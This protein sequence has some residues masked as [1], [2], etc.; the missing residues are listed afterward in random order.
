MRCLT[1]CAS[2]CRR[3]PPGDRPFRSVLR[4]AYTGEGGLEPDFARI[5]QA[6][7]PVQL[8]HGGVDRIRG[9]AQGLLLLSVPGALRPPDFSILAHG[10]QAIAHSIEVIGHVADVEHSV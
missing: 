8:L 4:L 5:T 2:A 1:T 6:L 9:H 7:G 3:R 10:P